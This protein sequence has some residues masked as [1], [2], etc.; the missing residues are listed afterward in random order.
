MA[1]VFSTAVVEIPTT[2]TTLNVEYEETVI[3]EL[4]ILGPQ[5]V[6]GADG[7]TGP[8]GPTGPT[9]SAGETGAT[10]AT[11]E[12]GSTG[13]T[14]PTGPTGATGSDGA[15][16]ETG[17]TGPTGEAGSAGSTGPTGPTGAT[18]SAGSAGARAGIQYSFN[19]NTTNSDPGSGVFKFNSSTAGSITE[20]YID[21]LAWGGT[22]V[23]S[24]IASWDDS[25]STNKGNLLVQYSFPFTYTSISFEITG[26]ITYT[27][28]YYTIPVSYVAGSIPPT[29]NL[30]VLNFAKTGD[31]GATG[32]TGADSTVPGPTG[33]TGPTGAGVD[34]ATGPTGPTGETG[35]TGPTG[36]TGPTGAD[37]FLGG[38]GPTGPTGPTG[39]T[40]PTG[41]NPYVQAS[42]PTGSVTGELWIDSDATG[43][44]LNSNDFV[45][46]Q[47]IYAESIHPFMVMGS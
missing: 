15:A 33:P 20:I 13:E 4:G 8:T 41:P 12:T 35:E 36:P 28:S 43:S 31:L 5:G 27:S 47:D 45:Q 10:G 32:A 19:S 6:E 37:G 38:T 25:T 22:N 9:G 11:G 46:K 34:G 21:E 23:G 29:G 7:A 26:T 2:T 44:A 18:G 14:G 42:E 39:E 3:V 17:P 1:T 40:G 30:M 24:V 16:G